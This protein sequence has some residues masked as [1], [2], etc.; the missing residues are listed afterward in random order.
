MGDG[1]AV[2]ADVGL[3]VGV[4]TLAVVGA[5]VKGAVAVASVVEVGMGS[6][7]AIART[8]NQTR[9]PG[10]FQYLLIVMSS[11]VEIAELGPFLLTKTAKEG[12]LF[13]VTA[14]VVKSGCGMH[15]DNI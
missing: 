12:I 3:A 14:P 6:P 5:G 13:P 4:G 10:S 7:Q 11:L 1:V 15:G 8:A 2:G 9:T